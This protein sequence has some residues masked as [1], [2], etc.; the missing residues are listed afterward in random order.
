[1][2][3]SRITSQR[4]GRRRDRPGSPLDTIDGPTSGPG[5]AER[6]LAFESSIGFQHHQVGLLAG[7]VVAV[8][9]VSRWLLGR[10]RR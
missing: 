5:L 7:V 8:G 2:S 1:M 4:R 9:L 6:V 3:T 10:A